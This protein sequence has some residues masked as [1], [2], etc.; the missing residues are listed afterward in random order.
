MYRKNLGMCQ[1]FRMPR[2]P[3][4]SDEAILERAFAAFASAGYDAMSVR[5]LNAELG[6]SHETISKRFG[7][8][9]DLFR[10]AVVYGVA[11]FIA[12]FD[13]AVQERPSVDDLERLN[14]MVRAFMVAISRNPTLGEL[15]HHEGIGE[16]DRAELMSESGLFERLAELVELL[17]RLHADGVIRATQLR[18]LWFLMQGAVGPLRFQGLSKMFDQ[19]DGPVDA[20]ELI[21]RMSA[22]IMR[23]MR[24]DD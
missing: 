20:D 1:P 11:I 7:P 15:L 2:P 8:K 9:A 3:L 16:P 5:A 19:V 6:L 4:L 21:E 18:E 12:D 22:A 17:D 14:A 10:A 24:V 13:A 23:G